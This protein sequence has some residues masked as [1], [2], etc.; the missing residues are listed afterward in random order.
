MAAAGKSTMPLAEQLKNR[1][2]WEQLEAQ[3]TDEELEF[4]LYRYVQLMGQFGRDGVLHTEEI[5]IFQLISNEIVTNR[6]LAGQKYLVGEVA[7][8]QEELEL[9]DEDDSK[10][11]SRA[12]ALREQIEVNMKSL[13]DAKRGLDGSL[14]Q[15]QSFL[16]DLKGLREQRI[17][18]LESAGTSFVEFLRAL[19]DED[20]RAAQDEDM[21]LVRRAAEKERARLSRPH[22]YLDGTVEPPLLTPE[23]VLALDDQHA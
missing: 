5:M 23:T 9:L 3:F 15:T 13:G 16:K 12:R 1:P 21:E 10:S 17:K 8:L 4:F 19:Q 7:R 20:F 22:T 11:R 14:K 6:S 18:Q 2:E